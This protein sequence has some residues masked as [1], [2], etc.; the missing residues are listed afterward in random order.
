MLQLPDMR[1]FF[2]KLLQATMSYILA[3]SHKRPFH[4]DRK[5]PKHRFPQRLVDHNVEDTFTKR[6]SL[7]L[8]QIFI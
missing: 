2:N 1:Y 5:T 8:A 7:P 4:L 3:F 6:W